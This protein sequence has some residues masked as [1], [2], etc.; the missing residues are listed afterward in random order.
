M[1]ASILGYVF[2]AVSQTKF[3]SQVVFMHLH[4]YIYQVD[5]CTPGSPNLSTFLCAIISMT[6]WEIV[7]VTKYSCGAAS[8]RIDQSSYRLVWDKVYAFK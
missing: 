4:T 5:F 8:S 1:G 6:E 2:S 7:S 3:C